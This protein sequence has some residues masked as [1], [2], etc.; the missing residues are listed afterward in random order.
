MIGFAWRTFLGPKIVA[1]DDIVVVADPNGQRWGVEIAAPGSLDGVG[2]GGAG[3][4]FILG[5]L[6]TASRGWR[7]VVHR[8]D[9]HQWVGPVHREKVKDE[10]AARAASQRIVEEIKLG[11][12]TPWV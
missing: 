5:G 7:V 11:A 3:L 1:V 2:S 12:W 6:W 8:I 4:G 9:N 10:V